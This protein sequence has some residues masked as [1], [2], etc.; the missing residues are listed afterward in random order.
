[1]RSAMQIVYEMRRLGLDLMLGSG[2]E[3]MLCQLSFEAQ[4][5]AP[6][7]A[8]LCNSHQDICIHVQKTKELHE[9]ALNMDRCSYIGLTGY[10]NQRKASNHRRRLHEP[11]S[12]GHA[13][14]IKHRSEQIKITNET[15]VSLRF[16]CGHSHHSHARYDECL[17]LLECHLRSH[18]LTKLTPQ[19]SHHRLERLKQRS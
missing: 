19:P 4:V 3:L 14:T 13:A 11:P 2:V 6:N 12:R 18:N 16:P 7:Q 17:F 15:S 10:L 5:L 1:V 9:S 8:P